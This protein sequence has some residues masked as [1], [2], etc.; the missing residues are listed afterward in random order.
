MMKNP[1]KKATLANLPVPV[2]SWL[3]ER[4]VYNGGTISSEIAKCCREIMER[5]AGAHP[6][7]TAE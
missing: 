3:K 1:N 6:A 4:A 7:A 5:E 2:L